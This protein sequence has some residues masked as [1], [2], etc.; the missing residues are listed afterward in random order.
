MPGLR[1]SR[2]P[3]TD[4]KIKQLQRNVKLLIF[5]AQEFFCVVLKAKPFWEGWLRFSGKIPIVDFLFALI[6]LPMKLSE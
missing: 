3:A 4:Q 2:T 5:K 6:P 1:Q